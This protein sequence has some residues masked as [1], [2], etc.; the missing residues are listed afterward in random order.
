MKNFWFQRTVTW[1][2]FPF[3]CIHNASTLCQKV[4]WNVLL[5]WQ[6]RVFFT[7]KTFPTSLE[8]TNHSWLS[9][10]S[11][12]TNRIICHSVHLIRKIYLLQDKVSFCSR[13]FIQYAYSVVPLQD[14]CLWEDLFFWKM[15]LNHEVASLMNASEKV[16]L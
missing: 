2:L 9:T 16:Y 3:Y 6:S 10:I 4:S 12:L 8:S 11:E 7:L 1:G 13:Y 14:S 5:F 15:L